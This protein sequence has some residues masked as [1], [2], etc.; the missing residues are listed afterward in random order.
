LSED[1]FVGKLRWTRVFCVLAIVL[2]ITGVVR[3]VNDASRKQ[4]AYSIVQEL[5]GTVG[6]VGLDFWPFGQEI[7]VTFRNVSLDD[8]DLRRLEV[9]KRLTG[10]H[11]VGVAFV[12]TNLTGL[13]VVALRKRLSGCRVFRVEGGEV[14]ADQ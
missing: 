4:R 3:T 6:S 9:L 1:C 13:D 14:V 8:D 12:D 11:T 2:V 10:R 7:R 5:G